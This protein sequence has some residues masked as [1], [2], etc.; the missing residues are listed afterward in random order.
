MNSKLP[1]ASLDPF[2][3]DDASRIGRKHPAAVRPRTQ[4]IFADYENDHD[5]DHDSAE[6]R[7]RCRDR[8]RFRIRR[9]AARSTVW[10]SAHC[11]TKERY[12]R[13][14][15]SSLPITTTIKITIRLS[16]VVVVVIVIG[17]ESDAKRRDPPSGVRRTA[18][19]KSAIPDWAYSSAPN[20]FAFAQRPTRH[21]R[22]THAQTRT[23]IRETVE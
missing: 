9:E 21:T 7:G 1:A 13:L 5:H 11:R 18:E 23:K 12:P 20:S 10:C 15:S 3:C 17:F 4:R 6:P 14:G 22:H 2:P 16:L 19:P 8:R